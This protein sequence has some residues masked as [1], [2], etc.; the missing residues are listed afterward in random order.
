MSAKAGDYHK[1]LTEFMTDYVFP[2]E[3][4]YDKYREEAGPHDHTVPPVIEELK[5]KA[6]AAGLWNLFLPAES[7]LT[8]LDYAPL[9]EL[10]G[11]SGDRTRGAQLRGT[12]HRQHGDPAPVR[13]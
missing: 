3:A 11:W 13:H 5:I 9:A 8:N 6:K 1:R 10:T 2:A 12:R 7:G 4:D